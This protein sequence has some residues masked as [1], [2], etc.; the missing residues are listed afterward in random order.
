VGGA[1][2]AAVQS[3]EDFSFEY[4]ITTPEGLV[5]TLHTT[6]RALSSEPG[7]IT[8]YVGITKDITE[9]IEME[10]D[11]RKL[12]GEL[13]HVTR[14]TTLGELAASIAHEVNQPLTGIVTNSEASLRWLD[15]EMPDLDQARK[16]MSRVIRDGKR[17]AEIIIRIRQLF[18]KD[19][20]AKESLDINDLVQD[21]VNL[22]KH[23]MEKGN[24]AFRFDAATG[25]PP[26]LGDRVQ[27]QQVLMNLIL[28]A[29][30][31][32]NSVENHT[33]KLSIRTFLTEDNRVGIEVCDNGPG[34]DPSRAD[35]IFDPFHTS[36]PSGMGMGLSICRSIIENHG[37][38]LQLISTD[39]IGATFRFTLAKSA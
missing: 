3:G 25:L 21:V 11:L 16:G 4:S 37:S 15:R 36:K 8:D 10:N 1:A 39:G 27:L 18:R 26:A 34:I 23:E 17:A 29:I 22:A 12:Q 13:A 14:V 38:K 33:R 35:Q 20:P 28:N 30:E 24:I 9:R 2:F 19:E 7:K 6:G 5:K 31:A 32:M